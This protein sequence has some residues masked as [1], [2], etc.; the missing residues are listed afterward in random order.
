[1]NKGRRNEL[2][3][4]KFKKRLKQLGLKQTKPTDF[5]CYKTTG[6][7]CSCPMCQP[8]KYNRAKERKDFTETY[9]KLANSEAF[10]NRYGNQS[11]GQIIPIE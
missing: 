7:P 5:I 2:T 10:L 1:M 3:K 11:V 8:H 4:L 9:R 6:N